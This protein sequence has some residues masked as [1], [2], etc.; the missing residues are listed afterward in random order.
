MTFLLHRNFVTN[1]YFEHRN[2][3]ANRQK[4]AQKQNFLLYA[5]LFLSS[6]YFQI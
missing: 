4:I 5:A 6:I 1:K 3:V 2:F